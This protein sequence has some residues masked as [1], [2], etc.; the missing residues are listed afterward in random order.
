MFIFL[1][2]LQ[3]FLEIWRSHNPWVREVTPRHFINIAECTHR[4]LCF[5][6]ARLAAD[7][8][9]QEAVAAAFSVVMG[10]VSIRHHS[11]ILFKP[12]LQK[13]KQEL[14]K[15]YPALSFLEKLAP[16]ADRAYFPA[17]IIDY[18]TTP[19]RYCC[20]HLLLLSL[21]SLHADFSS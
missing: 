9:P 14:D 19:A 2:S 15:R 21:F 7:F 6:T 18:L 12:L 16:Q 3:T 1:F 20:C 17:H 13:A 8:S 5:P 11:P 4:F 10:F